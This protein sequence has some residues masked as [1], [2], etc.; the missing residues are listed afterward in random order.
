MG[1]PLTCGAHQQGAQVSRNMDFF[2][3]LA[4]TPPR[5]KKQKIGEHGESPQLTPDMKISK[6]VKSDVLE[7]E[8]EKTNGGRPC[9][10]R[11]YRRKPDRTIKERLEKFGLEEEFTI[12]GGSTLGCITCMKY[13]AWREQASGVAD[14]TKKKKKHEVKKEKQEKR[15][16]KKKEEMQ[17]KEKEKK[18]LPQDHHTNKALREGTYMPPDDTQGRRRLKEVLKRHL[19]GTRHKTAE[20]ALKYGGDERAAAPDVPSDAQM[21]FVYDEVKKN[22]MVLP[23]PPCCLG[24]TMDTMG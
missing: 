24:D 13:A 23:L 2:D 17:E 18:A 21:M 8:H 14:A 20:E 15:R 6:N 16:M 5:E 9:T 4:S 22:P 3:L 19:S 10:G 7:E 11:T 1:L 12:C